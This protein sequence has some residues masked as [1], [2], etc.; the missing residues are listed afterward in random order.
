MGAI[1]SVSGQPRT[2]ATNAAIVAVAFAISRVLGLVREIAIASRFGTGE[3][4]D[5]YVAAFRI[6]DLLF[7]IVMSGAFGS[8]FIPVF[9][10]FLAE[11]DERRAWRLANTLVTYTVVI[12]AVVALVVMIFAEPLINIVV[13]PEL[14]P[15]SQ[16]LAVNLTRLLLVSPLLL[17]LSAAGKGMLEAQDAFTLPAI[18]PILYNL[19]IIFGAIALTPLIGIYG[20]AVG[21]IVGALAHVAVQLG[22]LL[23]SGVRF[24]P[25]LSLR[26]EGL[27]QV[28]RLMAPRVVGQTASQVNLIV[29]TNFASRLAEGSISALNYAQ[30]LVM[31]PHGVLAMSLSTVIF[32]RMARQFALGKVGELRQTLIGGL[33]PLLFL[34]LPAAVIL[35]VFRE[36][37]VQLVF[38]FGSFTSESTQLVADAVGFFAV[39]LLARSLIEPLTRAF[40]AMHD[41]RTPVITAICAIIIN[42][43]LSWVL[44]P[45]LGHSG[46]ALSLSITYTL[47]MLVL[48]GLLSRRTGGFG[49]GL[50]SSLSRMLVAGGVMALAAVAL[51]DPL[52]EITDP[53]TGRG[54]AA[55]V[56]FAVAML[57]VGVIYAGVAFALRVPEARQ[58]LDRLRR[59]VVRP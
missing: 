42:I 37:I 51:A 40:Y 49:A 55:Y 29:M 20:L 25:S 32:P 5:A 44:A 31:L 45:R 50:A 1:T 35:F 34:T 53:A 41:T 27:G 57:G 9:G 21:V 54:L 11:G 22:S 46:L 38:Q 58:V 23:R 7:F 16:E 12:F 47:R 30:H 14:S 19:G 36:S 52:Q 24:R 33:G 10:G 4:Y 15:E 43:G 18:A 26:T 6:P 3:A 17:G 59:R 48:A 56:A 39:G 8:A 13:A 2:V 28:G